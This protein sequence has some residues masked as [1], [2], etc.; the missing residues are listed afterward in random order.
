MDLAFRVQHN[1]IQR[2]I[3][4]NMV[5]MDLVKDYI[6]VV[7]SFIPLQCSY[8]PLPSSI[9][10]DSDHRDTRIVSGDLEQGP[11]GT[12]IPVIPYSDPVGMRSHS[13]PVPTTQNRLEKPTA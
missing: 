12:W 8:A 2:G 6:L 11:K 4:F 10:T 5:K 3:H 13:T 1:K 7:K 9:P